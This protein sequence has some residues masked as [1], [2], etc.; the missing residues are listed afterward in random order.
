MDDDD[1]ADYINKLIHSC[2]FIHEYYS[3]HTSL[4]VSAIDETPELDGGTCTSTVY[5]IFHASILEYNYSD[6]AWIC[7]YLGSR[8]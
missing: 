2:M 3:I 8:C 1:D 5:T 7:I 4:L 6:H